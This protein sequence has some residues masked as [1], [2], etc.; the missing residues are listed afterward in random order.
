MLGVTASTGSMGVYDLNQ[1]VYT[2]MSYNDGW[3]THPDGDR[4]YSAANRASGWSATLGAF[5]IAVMQE[6]GYL[7][8][9]TNEGDT[10]YTIADTQAASSYRT[11]LDTGGSD[12]IAYAGTRDAQI[13]LLAATLE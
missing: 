13:D 3:N 9:P 5:D 10:V 12:T 8:Q 11:I 1:G 6:R 2:V 4:N 7:T